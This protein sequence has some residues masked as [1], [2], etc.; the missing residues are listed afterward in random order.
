M[1][2]KYFFLLGFVFSLSCNAQRENQ[3]IENA[4]WFYYSYAMELNG[5]S[6]S[7]VKIDPL[8]CDIKIDAIERLK[9]DTTKYYFSLFQNDTL[10]ICYLKP[11][12]LVGVLAV[13]N[14]L[15]FPIYHSILFD[16]ESDSKI[17][18]RM[19]KQNSQLLQ[20]LL[21]KDEGVNSWLRTEA[22]LRE[23]K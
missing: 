23:S 15:Y 9:R 1:I 3:E 11:L 22:K 19:N 6:N 2:S 12:G 18:E 16:K 21:Q 14:K 7:G 8:A 17:L 5:Y 4:K 10:N 13:N 20:R